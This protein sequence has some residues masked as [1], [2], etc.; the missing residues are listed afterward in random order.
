MARRHGTYV[1]DKFTKA[2]LQSLRQSQDTEPVVSEVFYYERYSPLALYCKPDGLISCYI[3]QRIKGVGKPSASAYKRQVCSWEDLISRGLEWARNR[4]DS[5]V[6]SIQDGIDPKIESKKE[7]LEAE[8]LSAIKTL[9]EMTAE[10]LEFRPGGQPRSGNY[11]KEIQQRQRSVFRKWQNIKM[12]DI[13]EQMV[14]D[15]H[16]DMS[17]SPAVANKA[18]RELSAIFGYAKSRYRAAGFY[19]NNPVSILSAEGRWYKINPRKVRLHSP[20]LSDYI[21]TIFR[22]GT[23]LSG[24]LGWFNARDALLLALFTGLRRTMIFSVSLDCI[25]QKN[26]AIHITAEKSKN[27]QSYIIPLNTAAR[28]IVEQRLK[29]LKAR[30][31]IDEKGK[32]K[33]HVYLFPGVGREGHAADTRHLRKSIKEKVNISVTN[34]DLRRTFKS[35]GAELGINNYILDDLVC[36]ERNKRDVNTHYQIFDLEILRS[37]SQRIANYIQEKSGI[38]VAGWLK[39][40][41]Y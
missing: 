39:R 15:K 28:A 38:E 29:M 11:K 26:N 31:L 34:H 32:Q 2:F 33:P 7:A 3:Y 10:F 18:M 17:L 21:E 9:E 25:D 20:Q 1:Q 16:M 6:H 5:L 19:A 22:E 8:R 14:I 30:P 35:V 40:D 23:R 24:E 13:T 37:A 27:G 4:A 41:E 36:H 12:T